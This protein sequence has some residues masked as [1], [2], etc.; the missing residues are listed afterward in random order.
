MSKRRN[1]AAATNGQHNGR[2]DTKA[3]ALQQYQ[4]TEGHF[5]LVR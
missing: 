4:L 2:E 3:A 5:S 1:D